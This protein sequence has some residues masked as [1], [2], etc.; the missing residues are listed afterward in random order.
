MSKLTEKLRK[1]KI[2]LTILLL[3]LSVTFYLRTQNFSKTAFLTN[4]S[5]QNK[6]DRILTFNTSNSTIGDYT[7]TNYTLTQEACDNIDIR[8]YNDESGLAAAQANLDKH[9]T[10]GRSDLKEFLK[11]ADSKHIADYYVASFL[12][13]ITS[14]I[15]LLLSIV[16]LIYLSTWCLCFSWFNCCELKIGIN[17]KKI[18]QSICCK[19]CVCWSNV[20][21][22]GLLGFATLLWAIYWLELMNQVNLTNC[23][24]WT[25]FNNILNGVLDVNPE[26]AGITGHDWL[27]DKV[28][29]EFVNAKALGDMSSIIGAGLKAKSEDLLPSLE[30]FNTVFGDS[31]VRSPYDGTTLI[32]PDIVK[33][34]TNH[35]NVNIANEI[36]IFA[37]NGPYMEDG[38]SA[39]WDLGQSTEVWDTFTTSIAEAK[40][41]IDELRT[42]IRNINN[43]VNKFNLNIYK[44]R[45]P[46]IL[47]CILIFGYIVFVVFSFWI[48]MCCVSKVE[49]CKTCCKCWGKSLMFVKSILGAIFCAI[50]ILF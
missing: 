36:S 32:Q 43:K 41:E 25:I 27:A 3:I 11:D 13:Y 30:T 21:I 40:T 48:V 37:N 18:F 16:C 44:F 33:L 28:L 20:V 46:L 42:T 31:T 8:Q 6:I 29:S 49:K 50:G 12:T 23:A 14:F 34:M 7:I 1:N 24:I 17:H 10:A 47:S 35:I 9:F 45:W 4:R 5:L 19:R 15:F 38:A 2:P 26:F 39:L 22:P